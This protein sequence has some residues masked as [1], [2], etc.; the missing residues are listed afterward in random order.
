MSK[1]TQVPPFTRLLG[2]AAGALAAVALLVWAGPPGLPA[3]GRPLLTW[4]ADTAPDGVVTALAAEVAWLLA[5]YLLGLFALGALAELSGR[6][7]RWLRRLVLRLAPGVLGVA[8]RA[9]L[10]ATVVG[11]AVL[12]VALPASAAPAAVVGVPRGASTGTHLDLPSLDRPGTPAGAPA[13][14]GA[15]GGQPAGAPVA[16]A[17]AAAPGHPAAARPVVVR[18][19]DTLWSLAAQSLGPGATAAAIN[20][21]WHAWYAANRTVIGADPDLLHPGQRLRPPAA[22]S[23]AAATRTAQPTPE[24]Y[25]P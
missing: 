7:G 16:A 19:G 4:L 1:R 17:P 13:P 15:P 24:E 10:G 5:L 20:A 25:A 9:A 6:R 22:A 2:A 14:A 23:P 11:G 18:P 3:P 12:P 8:L 21:R